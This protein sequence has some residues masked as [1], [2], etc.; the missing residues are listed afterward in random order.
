MSLV[1]IIVNNRVIATLIPRLRPTLVKITKSKR[2][3]RIK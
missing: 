2:I 3:I 1:D